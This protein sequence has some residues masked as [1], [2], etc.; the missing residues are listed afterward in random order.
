[1]YDFWFFSLQS[2]KKAKKVV[3]VAKAKVK[4]V[5]SAVAPKGA[6]L[7]KSELLN[8]FCAEVIFTVEY[9]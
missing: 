1:M 3:K 8:N 7:N 9:K 2:K 4:K 6:Y 5:F